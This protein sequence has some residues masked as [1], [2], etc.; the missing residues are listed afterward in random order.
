MQIETQAINKVFGTHVALYNVSIAVPAGGLSA[1]LGP[2]GS[3]KTTLLRIIAGI[4]QP[5]SGAVRIGGRDVTRVPVRDR[6]IGFVFQNYALFE[7]MTVAE[8]IGFGLSVRKAPKQE[9]TDRVKELLGLIQ[10]PGLHGRLPSELSG[11]QRQRVALAR[12]LAP[13]PDVLLLDEPFGALDAKVR[14]ELRRWIR[15]LHDE[16]HITSVFVTHDQ[17]E[18][19]EVADHVAI[20]GSGRIEQAGPPS[21]VF[22]S[23]ATPFV[24]DFLGCDNVLRGVV[25][26]QKGEFGS[27]R[28]PVDIQPRPVEAPAK[29]Y[30]RADE[31]D[32]A[33]AAYSARS[34]PATVV[35]TRRIA[36]TVRV[37]L[38]ER[39]SGQPWIA[40][41]SHDLSV[42][43]GLQP[44]ETLWLTP[45]KVRVFLEENA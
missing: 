44:G 5:D 40:E 43:L 37:S 21:G 4:E 16:V 9:I 20:M 11:G 25:R 32:L 39:D 28:T 36:S 35:S 26:G 7:H 41:V 18:A 23:P 45:K 14:A 10:L 3:G 31:L 12:A 1:L 8:N 38:V 24:A 29:A 13:R 22:D 15:Q 34:V 33:R 30:V 27:L 2:S 6:N 17:E 42:D 19:F